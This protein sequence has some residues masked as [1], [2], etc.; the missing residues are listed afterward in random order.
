M[1]NKLLNVLAVI[2][3]ISTVIIGSLVVSAETLPENYLVN[4]ELLHL[5]NKVI[6]NHGIVPANEL[7]KIKYTWQFPD[8][9][10]ILA[11]ETI[12][13]QF[14]SVLTPVDT[15][16]M[17]VKSEQGTIVGTAKLDLKAN[18]VKLVFSDFYEKNPQVNR[19]GELEIMTAFA[20][21]EANLHTVVDFGIKQVKVAVNKPSSIA[22]DGQIQTHGEFSGNHSQIN[23]QIFAN[24]AGE[25]ITHST[26]KNDIGDNQTLDKESVVAYYGHYTNGSFVRSEAIPA[27][28]ISYTQSGFSVKTGDLKTEDATVEI[29]FNTLISNPEVGFYKNTASFHGVGLVLKTLSTTLIQQAGQGIATGDVTKAL[30]VKVVDSDRAS[31]GLSGVVYS[32]FDSKG[33]EYDVIETNE[34]GMARVNHIAHGSYRLVQTKAAVNYKK[35]TKE[36][37][38]EI[39]DNSESIT[40]LILK[41]KKEEPLVSETSEPSASTEETVVPETSIPAESSGETETPKTSESTE[42][43]FQRETSET[44][45][46]VKKPAARQSQE[47][48]KGFNNAS[49]KTIYSPESKGVIIPKK[50]SDRKEGKLHV[51][52]L[53]EKTEKGLKGAEFDILDDEGKVVDHIITDKNGEAW[54]KKLLFGDYEI[55]E[56]KTPDGY[57]KKND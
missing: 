9:K 23:W 54:T 10:E 16:E 51:I 11:G 36:F 26:L 24:I 39:N 28:K 34:Q 45:E 38:V 48:A 43:T 2:M 47:K 29:K 55:V 33:K 18:K 12:D 35:S 17:L 15:K 52:K 7:T 46:S 20:S 44:R 1:K 21:K 25:K 49:N 6:H 30:H 42:D 41:N 19:Q 4:A 57:K 3:L 22:T 5:N 13:F 37:A 31:Q 40:R 27:E 56:T 53:D 50:I 8:D 32:L 14:P